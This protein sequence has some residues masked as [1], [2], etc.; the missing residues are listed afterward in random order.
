MQIKNISYKNFNAV[1]TSEGVVIVSKMGVDFPIVM[2][3]NRTFRFVVYLGDEVN[4]S[5]QYEVDADMLDPTVMTTYGLEI[6]GKST[7][8]VAIPYRGNSLEIDRFFNDEN[9]VYVNKQFKAGEIP[10]SLYGNMNV[11]II[12][13]FCE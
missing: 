6:D 9:K 3:N 7:W 2:L 12:T 11:A 4:F 8:A 1:I 10:T 5:L 13:G